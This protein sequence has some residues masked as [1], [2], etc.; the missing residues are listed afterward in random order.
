MTQIYSYTINISPKK[1]LQNGK[2]WSQ[3]NNEE[4]KQELEYSIKMFL[5]GKHY[6]KE[7]HKFEL[8]A[9]KMIHVHGKIITVESV[10]DLMQTTFHNAYGFPKL[11]KS[12]CFK[13]EQTKRDINAW[14]VYMNKDQEE[15]VDECKVS[16][17]VF[18]KEEKLDERKVSQNVFDAGMDKYY[19]DIL[20][21]NT[22]IYEYNI[23]PLRKGLG[24]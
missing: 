3:L 12:I 19:R 8:T 17:N 1:F 2:I 16:Q 15:K 9:S 22:N 10:M 14:D 5:I 18:K 21:Y 7:E 24:D 23:G 4:Q 13:Y 11:R 20:E 6:E